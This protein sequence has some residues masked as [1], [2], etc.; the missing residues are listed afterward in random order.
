VENL[1]EAFYI[2]SARGVVVDANPA[3]LAMLGVRSMHDCGRIR[4]RT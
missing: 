4:C 3:F 1:R 2:T